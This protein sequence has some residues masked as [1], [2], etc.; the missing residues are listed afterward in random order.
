MNHMS[1]K[2]T[3]TRDELIILLKAANKAY[4]GQSKPPGAPSEAWVDWYADFIISKLR[5]PAEPTQPSQPTQAS[6]S[7]QPTQFSQAASPAQPPTAK[8]AEQSDPRASTAKLPPDPVRPSTDKLPDRSESKP[9]DSGKGLMQ[10]C[11]TCAHRNRTGVLFCENCG[12]NLMTGQQSALG[13]RDLREPQEVGADAQPKTDE[14]PSDDAKADERPP[15][16]LDKEVEK[17]VKSAGSSLFSPGMLLRIEVEGGASPIVVKPK[18]EDMILGRRDPTTGATP[19]VDLTA[20]AGYRM[21][22][23]RRHASLALENNQINLWDLGSSN[24]T[25]INGNRLTPHQP[26]PV[27]DGDEVRLGQMVLRLFFQNAPNSTS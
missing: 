21:G 22:V 2:L 1:E 13:T 27:R 18:T 20:Y 12:T 14:K 8:P 6:A 7:S 5:K 10:V 19:E 23:S 25:F 16:R 26:S 9:A 24:G 17:A 4:Q 11:P 15:I 3:I